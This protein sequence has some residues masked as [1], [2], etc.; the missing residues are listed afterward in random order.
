M[1]APAIGKHN[2]RLAEIRRAFRRG[3]LTP[4]GLLPIEGPHLLDEASK[5]GVE[6]EEL[7]V[8]EGDTFDVKA[9][10]S[11]SLTRSLFR[12]IRATREPQGVIGLVRPP[13]FDLEAILTRKPHL[14][15]VLCG[16]QDPGNVGTI[17]RIAEAFGATGCIGTRGTVG[18]YN[19]KLVRASGGSLFRLPHVWNVDLRP[20]VT[21]LRSEGVRIVGTARDTDLE[22][23]VWDW[24]E[25]SAAL[26]GNEASGLGSEERDLCDTILKI[27]HSGQVDSL[28]V[29]SA[30]AIALYEA[31]RRRRVK[32]VVRETPENSKRTPNS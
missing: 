27:P 26:F 4:D 15:V 13:Q 5:S 31:A 22:V 30:A 10:Q 18:L 16:L 7:F 32:E 17:L 3:E 23:D 19:D 11:H 25:C 28:N 2:P 24:T 12:S 1:K 29:A 21:R 20:I 9:Q 6:I 8:R 14:L